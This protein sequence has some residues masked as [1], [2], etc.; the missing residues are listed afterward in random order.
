MASQNQ[1]PLI[2]ALLC[3]GGLATVAAGWFGW[4]AV[5]SRLRIAFAEEQMQVFREMRDRAAQESH[6]ETIQGL[7]QYVLDYYPSGTKQRPGTPL[8]RIVET[9]RQECLDTIDDRWIRLNADESNHP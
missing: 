4:R 3:Y 5:E 1:R 7:R 6:P 2:I 9:T 8:D